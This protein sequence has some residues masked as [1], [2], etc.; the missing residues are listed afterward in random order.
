MND[1]ARNHERED[2][3]T[4]IHTDTNARTNTGPTSEQLTAIWTH[5]LYLRLHSQTNSAQWVCGL[6]VRCGAA[7]CAVN[8]QRVSSFNSLNTK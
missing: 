6:E 3:H 5:S 2:T 1:D 8:L 7:F 4:H